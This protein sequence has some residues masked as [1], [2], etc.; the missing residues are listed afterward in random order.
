MLSLRF[1]D[2]HPDTNRNRRIRELEDSANRRHA[3]LVAHK[4]KHKS[5]KQS[6]DTT[7]EVGSP[8]EAQ[9]LVVQKTFKLSSPREVSPGSGI[10]PFATCG[11]STLPAAI[12][13]A[14]NYSESG[15]ER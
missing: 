9:E 13:E 6:H 1:V 5:R 4:R 11:Y 3:S 15:S 14:Q 12:L 2:A 7:T 8:G 10:D